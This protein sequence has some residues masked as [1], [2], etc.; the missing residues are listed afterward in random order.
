MDPF[1]WN[2]V[3]TENPDWLRAS[4]GASGSTCCCRGRC[5][6]YGDDIY[7]DVFEVVVEAADGIETGIVTTDGPEDASTLILQ[8]VCLHFDG[9]LMR[10][11]CGLEFEK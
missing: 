4:G 6:C 9:V 7:E 8:Y 11:R 10:W 3:G 2:G 1:A 5:C